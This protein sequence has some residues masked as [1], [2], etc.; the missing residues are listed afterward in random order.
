MR[1]NNDGT[2]ESGTENRTGQDA[3]EQMS[4]A[5]ADFGKKMEES[6]RDFSRRSTA[7]LNLILSRLISRR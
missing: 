7:A 5:M 1:D 4:Q 6:S 3:Y 2:A